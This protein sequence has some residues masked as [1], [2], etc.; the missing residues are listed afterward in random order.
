MGDNDP[1]P[2]SIDKTTNSSVGSKASLSAYGNKDILHGNS[3]SD[4]P[5]KDPPM[6]TAYRYRPPRVDANNYQ[7]VIPPI[8][9]MLSGSSALKAIAD[10]RS[11]AKQHPEVYGECVRCV[12]CNLL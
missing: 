1:K 3:G 12:L 6:K 8:S 11:K 2:T 9:S 7:A 10:D 5:D 4:V